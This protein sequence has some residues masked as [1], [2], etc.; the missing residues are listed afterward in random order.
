MGHPDA[1]VL[2][3]PARRP[4]LETL[5]IARH[6]QDPARDL[7]PSRTALL[8]YDMQVGVLRQIDGAEAVIAKVGEALEAA[9]SAG[10]RVAFVRHRSMPLAWMGVMQTHTAMR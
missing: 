8:V 1:K 10:V 5:R 7:A 2:N 3:V 6:P 4:A 9:R